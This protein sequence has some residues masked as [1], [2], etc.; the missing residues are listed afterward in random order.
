MKCK[1][2]E[3][4]DITVGFLKR[5]NKNQTGSK[6]ILIIQLKDLNVN[7]TIDYEHFKEEEIGSNDRYPQ[8][9]PGDVVFA[10]KGSKRSA[11]V[12]DRDIKGITA[13]N[14]YLI[15][16]LKEE[17]KSKV[18][19]EYLSFYLRQKPSI[20]YFELH[21]TGSYVPFISANT[22][23]ELPVNVPDMERQKKI[24][25]LDSL[26][27]EEKRLSE[28]LQESKDKLYKNTISQL[29]MG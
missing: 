1:L 10:A 5:E 17:Y 22:I 2:G 28:E 25:E 11:G 14:H 6:Y 12:I 19:P 23:K 27:S 20:E 24:T 3:I 15:I 9:Y 8:L 18:L 4:T 21:G 13:S 16:R 29:I 7:G 26:I